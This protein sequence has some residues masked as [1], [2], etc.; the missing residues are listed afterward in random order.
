MLKDVR[1]HGSITADVDFYANLAGEKLLTA[2]FYEMRESEDGS[3]ISFFLAG[4]YLKLDRTGIVFSGTGGAVS[5]YMFG[6]PMPLQD[7]GHKEVKNR[8]VFF[9][10]VAGNGGIAF[11]SNVSGSQTYQSLFLDGN[12]VSNYFF[13]VKVPWPYSPRRVQETLL[14]TL[15]R[16]LKRSECPGQGNDSGFTA[17]ILKELSEPEATLL[18][19]RLVHRPH[20]QFYQFARD[21]YRRTREWGEPQAQF[22]AR[23]ADEVGVEEYQRERLAID[24]LY[25]DLEHR[26][27]VDE[28]KDIL[29]SIM[30]GESGPSAVARLNS[31]RNLAMRHHLPLSLFDTLDGLIP[32]SVASRD[33]EPPYLRQTREIFEGLFLA[34]KAPSET[35]GD[36]EVIKLLENKQA[37]QLRRDNGFEEILLETGRMLDEKGI[38]T[39]VFESLEVFSRVVTYFDRLDNAEALFN[40]LAFMEEATLDESKVRSILGNKRAFEELEKGLFDRLVVR[41]FLKNPYTLRAGR[42]KV[43]AVV[44]G[45]E[46]VERG[47]KTLAAVASQVEELARHERSV[48]YLYGGIRSHLQRFYF[49]LANP[50]HVRLLERE[51]TG[52]LQKRMGEALEATEGDFSAALDVVKRESEYVSNVMPKVLETNDQDMRE[53]FAAASGVD[54]YRLEELERE[55]RQ[56][57]AQGA[58]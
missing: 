41:H 48:R 27:L 7:L 54:L 49:N 43:D 22:V 47:E 31:L 19:L 20:S 30:S 6:S 3:E 39:D 56:A 9:G 37:A 46:K 26:Q 44:K 23:L 18:L 50:L 32:A 52:E 29:L 42:L 2:P 53:Q 40:Q 11:T 13:L 17:E 12:A 25:K 4:M 1:I 8:L 33:A 15:G 57:H 24:I 16:V 38:E 45:L 21:Y 34:S 35:V 10:A 55:Y 58:G 5:E 36:P 51:V 28:Y 14:K